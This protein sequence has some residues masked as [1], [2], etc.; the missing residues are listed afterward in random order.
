MDQPSRTQQ[1][2]QMY[3]YDGD[4]ET[5]WTFIQDCAGCLDLNSSEFNKVSFMVLCLGGK[6][7]RWATSYFDHH[8]ITDVSFWRFAKD[9]LLTFGSTP[10]PPSVSI[11]TTR[12]YQTS[13]PS[14]GPDSTTSPSPVGCQSSSPSVSAGTIAEPSMGRATTPPPGPVGIAGVIPAPPR[15]RAR[16]RRHHHHQQSPELCHLSKRPLQPQPEPLPLTSRSSTRRRRH[17]QHQQS[18]EARAVPPVQE[19]PALQSKSE[20]HLPSPYPVPEAAP[21][22]VQEP[23]VLPVHK[24]PVPP[25]H[26]VLVCLVV[27]VRTSSPKIK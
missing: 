1:R 11:S 3:R 4:P 10:P 5:C 7:L 2:L 25:V 12:I 27:F 17:H 22:P 23:P 21:Q 8:P 20:L 14:P 16:R 13:L 9:L 15:S 26:E 6:A 18:P 19:A 24:V